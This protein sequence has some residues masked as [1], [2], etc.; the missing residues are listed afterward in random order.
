MYAQPTPGLS[1]VTGVPLLEGFEGINEQF[2]QAVG[3]AKD[4]QMGLSGQLH[5]G[6]LDGTRVDDLLPPVIAYFAHKYPHVDLSLRNFSLGA[7]Q[8]ISNG[9]QAAA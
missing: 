7:R 9:I 5:I 6:I 1:G 2:T 3:H 4:V 8:R